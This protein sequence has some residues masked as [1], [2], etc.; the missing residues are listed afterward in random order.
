MIS[1]EKGD[2]NFVEVEFWC[3]TRLSPNWESNFTEVGMQF[4]IVSHYLIGL[5]PKWE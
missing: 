2:A 5:S 3:I 4:E 1:T